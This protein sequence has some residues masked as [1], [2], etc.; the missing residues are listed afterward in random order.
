[1]TH[2]AIFVRNTIIICVSLS[3]VVS[4]QILQSSVYILQP[5]YWNHW[6]LVRLNTI[7]VLFGV[8]NIGW[9][10]DT[11]E[12]CSYSTDAYYEIYFEYYCFVSHDSLYLGTLFWNHR[13]TN[14]IDNISSSTYTCRYLFFDL[15]YR[16]SFC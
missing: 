4:Q 8:Y 10:I 15:W 7:F 12:N 6:V 11:Q 2:N 16:G 9:R 14:W 5:L 3:I 1:M 13:K